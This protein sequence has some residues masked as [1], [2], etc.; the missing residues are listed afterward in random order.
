MKKDSILGL[1]RMALKM[2]SDAITVMANN[3]N[4]D[5]EGAVNA[6]LNCN[7]KLIVVGMGK[8]GHVANK[9]AASLASTGTPSFSL[10]PGEAFHGDLGMISGN[11]VVLAISKSGETDE[12]LKI[13]PFIKDS[14]NVLIAMTGNKNST[15]ALNADFH[16]DVWVEREVC[17]LDLAPT[18]STTAQMAMGD[19]LLVALMT[20][21]EFKAENFARYHP[22]GNLGRRLLLKVKD[23]MRCDDL[24]IVKL[25]CSM[26]ELISVVSSGRAGL[27][28]IVE[29]GAIEGVVTDGDIRRAMQNDKNNFFEKIAND[30]C[31]HN[32]KVILET[33]KLIEANQMMNDYKINTLL[34]ADENRAL[35]GIVQI[36]DLKI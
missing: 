23:V 30:I 22:G 8:S 17:P 28:V 2:E 20:L 25:N 14:G 4:A 34:V 7:G 18:T 12:L 19:A 35:K 5:F 9:I 24:P 31:N 1:A 15:L 13:V 36:Y 3:L 33:A 32:P 29:D 11:D 26:T 10:H 21:R 6:I 27:A 16:L